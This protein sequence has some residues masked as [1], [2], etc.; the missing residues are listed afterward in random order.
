MSYKIND[1]VVID[2]SRNVC[3][4]CVTSCCVT[5][6][7]QMVIPSGTTACRPTGTTGSLYYDTDEGALV[8]YNGTDWAKQGGAGVVENIFVYG[9]PGRGFG[10][11]C[12]GGPL[13]ISGRTTPNIYYGSGCSY[14]ANNYVLFLC[15]C[16]VSPYNYQHSSVIYTTQC[17][18]K[19]G[20]QTE[21]AESIINLETTLRCACQHLG[22]W[23]H[24]VFPQVFMPCGTTAGA[25]GGGQ[26]LYKTHVPHATYLFPAYLDSCGYL[27]TRCYEWAGTTACALCRFIFRQR[28]YTATCGCGCYI[29]GDYCCG[30]GISGF[31]CYGSSLQVSTCMDCGGPMHFYRGFEPEMVFDSSICFPASSKCIHS[32]VYCMCAIA[33]AN[34]IGAWHADVCI[35]WPTKTALFYTGV[36]KSN[37]DWFH[38]HCICDMGFPDC[39]QCWCLSSCPMQVGGGL[40]AWKNLNPA[41]CNM[42]IRRM[43]Y[44][45]T[46]EGERLFAFIGNDLDNDAPSCRFTFINPTSGHA[47]C[48]YQARYC[49]NYIPVIDLFIDHCNKLRMFLKD[50]TQVME[51]V[52]CCGS[53][54]D[55]TTIKPDFSYTYSV[56]F[57]LVATNH[58][59]TMQSPTSGPGYI[60]QEPTSCKIIYN[61]LY[62]SANITSAQGSGLS[63]VTPYIDDFTSGTCVLLQ[64]TGFCMTKAPLSASLIYPA[65]VC[66]LRYHV[67]VICSTAQGTICSNLSC[68]CLP[69]QTCI[70]I[71]I[72][73]GYCTP[74]PM[75][76]A[77]DGRQPN[78]IP[79]YGVGSGLRPNT[80]FDV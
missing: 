78:G 77:F 61:N 6:S 57:G 49:N 19:T 25:V 35:H 72:C 54:S 53:C 64:T 52:W 24:S 10:D 28:G 56:P 41:S 32:T 36:D 3:A 27:N 63:F 75:D 5:A 70:C 43:G 58:L 26:P 51:W 40:S 17:N 46:S 74:V 18:A 80:A 69:A 23:N 12:T 71:G 30:I 34:S 55:F 29:Y 7:S 31:M 2:D 59:S 68:R 45:C 15:W 67:Q 60:Y 16:C 73:P 38:R 62:C 66:T 50:S 4:C 13:Y 39:V 79:L 48:I 1:T 14:H 9:R 21:S 20:V 47:A 44:F 65:N 42:F 8:A 11:V 76:F 37:Y 33:A 22:V